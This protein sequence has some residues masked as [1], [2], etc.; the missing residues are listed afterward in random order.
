MCIPTCSQ[1]PRRI[2]ASRGRPCERR[3]SSGASRTA[4]AGLPVDRRG[5]QELPEH[6]AGVGRAFQASRPRREPDGAEPLGSSCVGTLNR[7]RPTLTNLRGA[8]MTKLKK[9]ANPSPIVAAKTT[10]TLSPRA[11]AL[12]AQTCVGI[13]RQ[14]IAVPNRALALMER[15]G[16]TWRFVLSPLVVRR[17]APCPRRPLASRGASHENARE[18]KLSRPPRSG[19]APRSRHTAA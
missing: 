2:R 1:S 19:A 4:C 17:N 13:A 14:E 15:D 5:H 10:A 3:C 8:V 16:H 6:Q 11:F 9:V 18:T 7:E 12:S